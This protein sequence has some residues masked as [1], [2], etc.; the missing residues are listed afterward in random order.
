[1]YGTKNLQT[2]EHDEARLVPHDGAAPAS[3]HL[4]DTV[5]APDQDASVGAQHGVEE[6]AEPPV[7]PE[8][9]GLGRGVAGAQ[10]AGYAHEVVG[11]HSAEAEQDDDLHGDAHDDDAVAGQQE[12]GVV[13]AGGGGEAAA[14]GL[15]HQARDVGRD[16][17]G[18]VQPRAHTREGRVQR[19]HHMLE[20]EVDG[21]ADQRWRENDGAD[22]RLE[23]ALVPRVV[24]QLY[25]P[26][27]AYAEK[28]KVARQ[29]MIRTPVPS[30]R[31]W[32]MGNSSEVRECERQRASYLVRRHTA[33]TMQPS[34]ATSKP[35]ARVLLYV[36]ASSSIHPATRAVE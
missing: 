29:Y 3:A 27:I 14:D 13:G 33:M 4:S 7:G 25:A 12:A 1:V 2:L 28:D 20:R 21:Y 24:V 32:V 11:A 23:G 35:S 30:K 31:R 10:P 16:E 26:Y 18:W 36:P 9:Q 19:Q 17:D 8:G 15:Q 5:D 34:C 22:L 6:D